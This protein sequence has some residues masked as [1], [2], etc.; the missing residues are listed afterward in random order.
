MFSNLPLKEKV[1]KALRKIDREIKEDENSSSDGWKRK[2]NNWP[3]LQECSI[4][5]TSGNEF[6]DEGS[7]SN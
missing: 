7:C 1:K 2:K 6:L 4:N 3:N 5:S